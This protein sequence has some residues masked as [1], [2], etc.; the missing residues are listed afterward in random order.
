MQNAKKREN[1][2]EQIAALEEDSVDYFDEEKEFFLITSENLQ[3]IHTRFYGYSIQ[4]NGIYEEDN[5]TE[6]AVAGLD[7]RGCYVYVEV[8]DGQITI[9][10]D[11]NGCWG[12]Y[13]FRHGDY[14]A[15]SNSFFR[16][17]DHI[18][19]RYPLTVN[20]DYCHYFMINTLCSHSYSETAVN[21]IS[22]IER[23]AILKIDIAK[24]DLQTEMIDY[25]ERC[26]LI[27]TE[28]GMATLDRWI[29]LW[30]SVLRNV[31]KRTDFLNADLSGGFDTRVPFLMMLQSGTDLKKISLNSLKDP[32]HSEDYGIA[33]R[34]AA[35]YGLELNKPLPKHRF[36]NYSLHDS[37]NIDLHCR[38]T[39]KKMPGFITQKRVDKLYSF[40]GYAGET[41]RGNWLRFHQ[42]PTEFIRVRGSKWKRYSPALAEEIFC[43]VENILKSAFDSICE[44]YNCKNKESIELVQYLYQETRCRSHYGKNMVGRYLRNVIM[45]SP[46]LDP[47][48]RTLR[49]D[50][51]ECRNPRLLLAVIFTRYEPDLLKFPF[52][53][54]RIISPRS[55]A[56]AEK[57]NERFPRRLTTS[58]V[59]GAESFHLQPIDKQAEK[60]FSS[61]KDNKGLPGLLLQDCQK[62]AF[63]SNKT[64]GL[65]STCFSPE[66]YHYAAAF[67]ENHHKSFREIY[68][69]YGIAKVLEDTIIS[70]GTH[71][72]GCDMKRFIEDDFYPIPNPPSEP[73]S[74][75][76]ESANDLIIDSKEEPATD[77]TDNPI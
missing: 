60:I 33:S 18:K 53:G 70:T 44:K 36:L 50:T 38:Q 67:Y 22:L 64:Y 52:Q 71:P 25:K 48:V 74:S 21:E 63:D 6:E 46:A 45:L 56:F 72:S 17:L 61:G 31:A 77:S 43:S 54:N 8:R 73:P 15:L 26:H 35:H 58:K 59:N 76:E 7:G 24:K 69:V 10:Q 34:I 42:T 47:L 2:L 65:F 66:L 14:F 11:L 13:L 9:K 62:A 40:N 55:I 23:H 49:I 20:R 3:E 32:G 27:Y 1:L 75:E 39:F 5:L 4:A 16:L 68:A 41:V 28:E 57:I 19:F 51:P 12:I 29:E 37:L 30:G